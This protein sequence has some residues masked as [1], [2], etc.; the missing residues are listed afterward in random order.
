QVAAVR[1]PRDRR[2]RRRADEVWA[3]LRVGGLAAVLGGTVG[4]GVL[5]VPGVLL[6][7]S[8]PGADLRRRR[9]AGG[10]GLRQQGNSAGD[11]NRQQPTEY[12]HL[13]PTSAALPRPIAPYARPAV[14]ARR[15]GLYHRP[16]G[17]R[18]QPA[19]A[20]TAAAATRSRVSPPP[21]A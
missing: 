19:G 7:R 21:T 5:H 9:R 18:S 1:E 10:R 6:E 4:D 14:L 8:A 16:A 13:N 11:E 3:Q 20:A 2:S 15:L 12:L 17:A